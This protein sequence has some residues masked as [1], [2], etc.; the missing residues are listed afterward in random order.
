[1]RLEAQ[2][3][4]AEAEGETRARLAVVEERTRIAREM[5][6]VVAHGMS[7]ISVQASAAQEIARSDPDRTID[8][9]GDIEATGRE[10]LTEMR[11]MLGVLRSSD[12]H[13]GAL[14]PQPSLADLN[15]AIARCVKAGLPTE[16]AI[17]GD[18]E[19]LA[20]GLE[21]AAFRIAQEALTNV[22]KHAGN[23]ATAT[24]TLDYR[25]TELELIIAD[26]GR[27]AVSSLSSTGGGNGLMGMRERV[28]AYNGHITHGPNPGGGYQVRVVFPLDEDATRPSVTSAEP[29][30]REQMT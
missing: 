2:A 1:M 3:A 22:L 21:L 10:A 18:E 8:I 19:R 29:A 20:P 23:P 6:D 9:L 26:T 17:T 4:L 15:S 27:G 25:P 13:A 5:H 14:S 16:L 24:V 28:D 12:D 11:R 7:V 30:N